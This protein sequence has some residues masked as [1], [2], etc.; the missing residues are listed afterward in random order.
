MGKRGPKSNRAAVNIPPEHDQKLYELAHGL[1]V[2]KNQFDWGYISALQAA[3]KMIVLTEEITMFGSPRSDN[4]NKRKKKSKQLLPLLKLLFLDKYEE[5]GGSFKNIIG[6]LANLEDGSTHPNLSPN[7]IELPRTSVESL[8]NR[9]RYR[10]ANSRE[11]AYM[12]CFERY[13]VMWE[14]TLATLI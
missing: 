2:I 14:R 4:P 1:V 13:L 11:L 9:S 5:M 6:Y 7:L 10:K 3:G 12:R 8:E